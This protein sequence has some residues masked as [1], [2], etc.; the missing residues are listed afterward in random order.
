MG[1]RGAEGSATL[2]LS[3]RE[4]MVGPGLESRSPDSEVLCSV[5]PPCVS[6]V[7]VLSQLPVKTW[8]IIFGLS[9]SWHLYAYTILD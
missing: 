3:H 4:K 6:V 5:L 1:Q 7:S 9:H 8:G 2:P